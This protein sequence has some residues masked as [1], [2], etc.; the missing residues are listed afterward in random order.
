MR[1]IKSLKKKIV[2][3]KEK[4]NRRVKKAQKYGVDELEM[5]MPRFD[6]ELTEDYRQ[7]TY[8]G[9]FDDFNSNDSYDPDRR[10]S[11][12]A[13]RTY[14]ANNKTYTEP[15]MEF[16]K[17]LKDNNYILEQDNDYHPSGDSPVSIKKPSISV[18]SGSR[19]PKSSD[20]KG[21]FEGK[22]SQTIKIDSPATQHEV[23]NIKL[24]YLIKFILC[25]VFNIGYRVQVRL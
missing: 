18:H 25:T 9:D 7:D 15:N 3:I 4:Y 14:L 22:R 11:S 19:L 10:T 8:G 24:V 16:E 12:N 5:T 2:E 1:N 23:S 21:G 17:S 13:Y 20:K 6:T